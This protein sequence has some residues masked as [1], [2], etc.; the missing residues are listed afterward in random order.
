MRLKRVGGPSL[1]VT[2]C[3]CHATVNTAEAVADLDGKPWEAYY[4]PRCVPSYREQDW[5][6][7]TT[8][9]SGL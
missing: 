7:S 2:C 9:P 5:E 4:C 8:N 6:P 3:K 1:N